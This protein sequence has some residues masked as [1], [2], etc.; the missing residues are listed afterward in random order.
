MCI[1]RRCQVHGHIKPSYLR[2]L[3]HGQANRSPCPC[4]C[5]RPWTD[6]PDRICTRN[7][8]TRR[9]RDRRSTSCDRNRVSHRAGHTSS[10]TQDPRAQT[11]LTSLENKCFISFGSRVDTGANATC[12]KDR[13][14]ATRCSDVISLLKESDHELHGLGDGPDIYASRGLD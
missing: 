4:N 14:H 7:N 11:V 9:T 8:S 1:G 6:Q 2:H 13:L 10:C 5:G 12:C 3:R